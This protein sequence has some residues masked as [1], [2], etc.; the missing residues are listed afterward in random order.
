MPMTA[1]HETLTMV[2]HKV[3]TVQDGDLSYDEDAEDALRRAAATSVAAADAHRVCVAAA[4][5]L[6]KVAVS[7]EV[8]DG[9]PAVPPARGTP[10]TRRPSTAR[11]APSS[12]TT[13][14]AA[15]SSSAP[16]V[17][18]GSRCHP[19]P[20]TRRCTSPAGGHAD[21]AMEALT[22][23]GDDR[24]TRLDALSGNERYTIQLSTP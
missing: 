8:W 1:R 3:F 6:V 7:V 19:A 5:T 2:R 4:Q 22:T 18:A 24:A 11:P 14:P 17:P 23:P 13:R 16:A 21:A 20:F 12:S 15:R 10:C 9:S